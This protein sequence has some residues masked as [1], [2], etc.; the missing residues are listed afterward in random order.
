MP[1]IFQILTQDYPVTFVSFFG[2]NEPEAIR[3]YDCNQMILTPE[4][5]SSLI[6]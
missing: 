5:I 2:V 3:I 4:Y 6:F 1:K